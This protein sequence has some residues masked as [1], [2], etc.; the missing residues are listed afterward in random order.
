MTTSHDIGLPSACNHA[1]LRASGPYDRIAIRLH[2]TCAVTVAT[3]WLIAKLVSFLPRGPLRLDIWSAHVLLGFVLAL[4]V[5]LRIVWRLRHPPRETHN[6][7]ILDKAASM[8]HLAL[9][10]LMTIVVALGVANAFLRGYPLFGLWALPK[11]S[12]DPNLIRSVTDWH[13]LIA[14]VLLTLAGLHAIAALFHH[15]VLHDDVLDRMIPRL[16]PRVRRKA[17]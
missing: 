13:G 7:G 12:A 6:G 1:E 11:V 15:V 3:L 2:W 5:A 4:L 10:A 14:N 9:Y 16:A 8:V 17:N